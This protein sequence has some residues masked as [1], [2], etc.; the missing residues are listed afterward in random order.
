MFVLIGVF[1]LLYIL[2][3]PKFK[4]K[5]W[6]LKGIIGSVILILVG[7]YIMFES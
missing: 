6:D 2:K 1:I 4:S 5:P 7:I 3:K